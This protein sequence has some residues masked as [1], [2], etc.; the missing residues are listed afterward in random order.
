MIRLSL[1]A[2]AGIM[3]LLLLLLLAGCGR[4]HKLPSEL[5]GE[6]RCLVSPT[7]IDFGT[8][9]IGQSAERTFTI[10]NTG[11]GTL[12]G[13]V[14]EGCPDYSIV[15]STSYGLA[16]GQS[17]TIRIRF[18]PLSPG[19]KNCDIATGSTCATDTVTGNAQLGATRASRPYRS[20]RAP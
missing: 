10:A 5:I 18:E 12:S 14:S 8:V 19:Q 4:R 6:P 20:S 13:T 15:G 7:T 11:E 9:T 1:A 16:A 3:A 2:D 17:A